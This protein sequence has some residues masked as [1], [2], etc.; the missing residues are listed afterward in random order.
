[1]PVGVMCP[2]LVLLPIILDC[3]SCDGLFIVY[4]NMRANSIKI[5]IQGDGV[6]VS[7]QLMFGDLIS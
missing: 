5:E 7:G 6:L 2:L 1:M 4:I 3:V